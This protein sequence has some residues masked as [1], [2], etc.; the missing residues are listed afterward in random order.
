MPRCA[1]AGFPAGAHLIANVYAGAKRV[2]GSPYLTTF[3][4]P[5][6]LISVVEEFEKIKANRA[7]YH[8]GC[9]HLTGQP[10]VPP[11]NACAENI[12]G[13]VGTYVRIILGKTTLAK[14]PHFTE[15]MVKG[16]PD[17]D[18]TYS[19]NLTQIQTSATAALSG[20]LARLKSLTSMNTIESL[21]TVTLSFGQEVSASILTLYEDSTA[22]VEV[23]GG[24]GTVA[25]PARV[26]RKRTASAAA[27][28][29]KRHK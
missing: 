24:S 21:E 23:A 14:S 12:R 8:I 6:G 16:A 19:D 15:E 28:H 26:T 11:E 29:S 20:N 4:D 22:P 17:Y 2:I 25:T 18:T 13:R 9:Y 27:I 5:M 1:S 3:P 7:L 10:R